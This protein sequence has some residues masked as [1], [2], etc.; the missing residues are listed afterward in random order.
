MLSGIHL[1]SAGGAVDLGQ[2]AASGMTAAKVNASPHRT[3]APGVRRGPGWGSYCL[4]AAGST[5]VAAIHCSR[6]L[7]M[8]AGSI[9]P[10]TGRA[11]Q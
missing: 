8:R 1:S 3:A 9:V 10:V 6:V 5:P 2:P 7:Q 11:A 4:G